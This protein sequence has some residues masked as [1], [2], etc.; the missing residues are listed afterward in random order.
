MLDQWVV[1]VSGA[2]MNEELRKI[3]D[4]HATFHK[5]AEDVRFPLPHSIRCDDILILLIW[6]FLQMRYTVSNSVVDHP[7]H[8]PTIRGPLT[9]NL[10]VVFGDVV[11]EINAAFADTIGSKL[12]GD[13][14][15]DLPVPC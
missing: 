15:S 11:D 5:A 6:Q 3:P 2:D 8:I 7:I 1:I 13:G 10:G 14:Q 12:H 9:K 4:S